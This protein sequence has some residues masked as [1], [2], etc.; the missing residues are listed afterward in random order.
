V[1]LLSIQIESGEQRDARIRKLEESL[2]L[3]QSQGESAAVAAKRAG[4]DEISVAQKAWAH[5]RSQIESEHSVRVT[6][7]ET[8]LSAARS[9]CD[10]KGSSIV[11]LNGECR[12]LKMRCELLETSEK[13]SLADLASARKRHLEA[14]ASLHDALLRNHEMEVAIGRLESATLEKDIVTKQQ[15]QLV[16]A[17]KAQAQ[18]SLH[19]CE[20]LRISNTKLEEKMRTAMSEITKGNHIIE[21]LQVSIFSRLHLFCDC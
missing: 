5:E 9:D 4:L 10:R 18:Q 20:S 13:A 19:E 6:R 16:D 15:M 11:Q 1:N 21:Q 14:D 2:S 3:A 12:E 17:A 8:E 7:L